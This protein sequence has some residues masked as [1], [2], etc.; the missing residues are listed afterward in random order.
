MS[1]DLEKRIADGQKIE[2]LS[3]K[4]Y[5]TQKALAEALSFIP[6]AAN[7]TATAAVAWHIKHA[8]VIREAAEEHDRVHLLSQLPHP[9]EAVVE[10]APPAAEELSSRETQVLKLLTLGYS[11]KEIARSLGILEM[12]V[13]SH[14]RAVMK[15]FGVQNRT[16][17]ALEGNRRMAAKSV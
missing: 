7:P 16:Q 17:A 12:T 4:L 13:K 6:D 2:A 3:A 8:T 14:V 10:A 5:E 1:L 11:N 15:K 9:P